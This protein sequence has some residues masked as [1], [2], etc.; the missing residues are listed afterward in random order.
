MPQ[1]LFLNT[2][3]H[4][5]S[6]HQTAL[7]GEQKQLPRLLTVQKNY[8][9]VIFHLCQPPSHFLI[10]N[11]MIDAS[12]TV[13]FSHFMVLEFLIPICIGCCQFFGCTCLESWL[14]RRSVEVFFC[15]GKMTMEDGFR[16]A[17]MGVICWQHSSSE[18]G[19]WCFQESFFQKCCSTAAHH[20]LP[21]VI[22][23][24]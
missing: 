23:Q 8:T 15:V 4:L 16:E 21:S 9:A 2:N 14:F 18:T 22:E 10:I 7:M 17:I 24:M 6:V 3:Q 19:S 20:S 5:K 1:K 13:N 12:E 11:T